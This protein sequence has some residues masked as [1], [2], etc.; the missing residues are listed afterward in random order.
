MTIKKYFVFNVILSFLIFFIFS[1]IFDITFK[2]III[3]ILYSF[4]IA[5]FFFI[6]L[7]IV[8][9]FSKAKKNKVLIKIIFFINLSYNFVIYS[10]YYYGNKE[11]LT[12]FTLEIVIP[13]ILNF[14]ELL[15][16][17]FFSGK[18]ILIAL[19]T[20]SIF[21]FL[22]FKLHRELHKNIVTKTYK[23]FYS[24]RYPK[25][26]VIVIAI[27]FIP[28]ILLKINFIKIRFDSHKSSQP[29]LTY[30][31]YN[32]VIESN[33]E[34]NIQITIEKN[35]YPDSQVFRKKNVILIICDALRADY[36]GTYGNK[37]NVSPFLDS[38][39]KSKDYL[40]VNNFYSTS[41]FS[42]KGISN[43]LSSSYKVYRDNFFL[44]DLL[45]KQGYDI[46]FL[47][48]GDMTNFWRLKNHIKT[49][50]VDLYHDG[51]TSLKKGISN[52]VNNDFYNVIK[53]LEGVK[54]FN[55]VP[56]MFYFHLMSTHQISKLE[57]SNKIFN[58]S[59]I[60]LTNTEHNK[61]VLAN[62]YNNR[63]HQLDN[64]LREIF[65]LLENKNYLENSIVVITSD[66]GQSL[67]ERGVYWHGKT[68][69]YESVNIPLIISSNGRNKNINRLS[70]Q[71]DI[72]PT[73]VDVLGIQKP[74][75]WNGVSVF[76]E[77][78]KKYFYQH[79]KKFYSSIWQSNNKIYQYIF[80][81]NKNS[82]SI[83]DLD[84]KTRY[85]NIIKEF[86]NIKVDSIKNNLLK[87]FN[88]K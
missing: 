16:S 26:F 84:K 47:L 34:T 24:H 72:A 66:H 67:G 40:K 10:L 19:F 77:S 7:V 64:Y 9:N 28:S 53:N 6:L 60:I 32:D 1:F 4:L 83:F 50:S 37:E 75:V 85:N 29:H 55:G 44:H 58:P 33:K 74:K 14:P 45:K 73:V 21:I 12:P 22:W 57:N 18:K 79:Q 82:H 68:T 39:V 80:N 20:F 27:F 63:V 70:N 38:I 61:K 59:D 52:N 36:I 87:N 17:D 49:K 3:H 13:Y 62:N 8:S 23:F 30:L 25:I 15:V 78:K 2:D 31:Y 56:T 5:F 43:I 46:N 81:K 48:S 65:N 76:K 54:K 69:Y 35:T 41:S 88:L 51:Y 42:Y 11:I 86:N 71:L